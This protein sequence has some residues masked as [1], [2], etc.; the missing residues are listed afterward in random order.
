MARSDMTWEANARYLKQVEENETGSGPALLVVESPFRWKNAKLGHFRFI[1]YVEETNSLFMSG[2][3]VRVGKSHLPYSNVAIIRDERS[4]E[5]S[6]R[7]FHFFGPNLGEP[8]SSIISF[9]FRCASTT[10]NG[11]M[12]VISGHTKDNSLNP[13]V[14]S[15]ASSYKQIF[16]GQSRLHRYQ[17]YNAPMPDIESEM[18]EEAEKIYEKLLSLEDSPYIDLM[19]ILRL[20][21]LAQISS[22][23]DMS[24]SYTLFIAS[25]DAAA[26][27]A[28]NVRI[29]QD[30]RVD[31][32]MHY[33]EKS[34]FDENDRKIVKGSL[35]TSRSLTEQFCNFVE[36]YLPSAFWN[37]DYSMIS[38]LDKMHEIY[39]SGQYY[40][41]LAEVAPT[42][43]ERKSLEEAARN[44][45]TQ[46]K[47]AKRPNSYFSN[48][49]DRQALLEFVRENMRIWLKQAFNMRSTMLHRGINFPIEAT[50]DS[51]GNDWLPDVFK[52]TNWEEHM[53]ASRK[54]IRQ[55]GERPPFH[56]AY[57]IKENG[58]FKVACK[59]GVRPKR[60]EMIFAINVFE[61]IVHDTLL[62]FIMKYS[63]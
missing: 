4:V 44:I 37:G 57:L 51:I 58:A 62:A 29:D 54:R 14:A 9:S 19:R 2:N 25:L 63:G 7:P 46:R 30:S 43:A 36:K 6:S 26:A 32:L 13:I 39:S 5:D 47:P 17:T 21:Q 53:E 59:C 16:L 50:G 31:G 28:G 10:Y 60:M 45:E 24:L 38:E 33:M 61:K 56:Q 12:P 41:D 8:I 20:Y 27:I 35:L 22:L 42:E 48:V 52:I 55:T 23:Y 3:I 18:F 40:R 11:D 15:W 1:P 34:G 49:N